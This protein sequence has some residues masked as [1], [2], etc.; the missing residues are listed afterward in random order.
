MKTPKENILGLNDGE[1]WIWPE[2]DYGKAEIWFKNDTYFLFEIP[3][4]GGNPQ[5]H[6]YFNIDKVDY[7]ISIVNSWT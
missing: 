2:S 7:L 5:F 1:S 4:F 3:Q 6:S